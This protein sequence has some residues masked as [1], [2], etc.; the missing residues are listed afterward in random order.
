[1]ER[2]RKLFA[3]WKGE[4]V[5]IYNLRILA[6]GTELWRVTEVAGQQ[7]ASIKENELNSTDEALRCLEDLER[8]L[9]AGGWRKLPDP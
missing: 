4:E 6:S 8:S 3:Y 9:T 7:R 5:R 2:E 1:M